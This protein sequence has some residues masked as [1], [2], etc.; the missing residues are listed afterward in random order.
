MHS[1]A[2]FEN[3]IMCFEVGGGG[4]DM[5]VYILLDRAGGS[6]LRRISRRQLDTYSACPE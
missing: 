5:L 2:V 1:K 3:D 4:G 6:V